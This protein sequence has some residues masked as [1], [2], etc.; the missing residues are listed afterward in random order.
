MSNYLTECPDCLPLPT[1]FPIHCVGPVLKALRGDLSDKKCALHCALTLVAW[2]ASL[3][4]NSP[5]SP[6]TLHSTAAASSGPEA[7]ARE[8]EKVA[9]HGKHADAGAAAIN[10]KLI[11]TSVLALIQQLL[12]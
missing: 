9:H 1:E 5:D 8:L 6:P 2:G 11:I 12:G 4:I 3:Y 7:A 10:W